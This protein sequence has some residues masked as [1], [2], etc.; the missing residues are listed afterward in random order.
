MIIAY[1]E[2]KH[3][4]EPAF[5]FF[6]SEPTPTR[7]LIFQNKMVARAEKLTKKAHKKRPLCGLLRKKKNLDDFLLK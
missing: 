2:Q 3:N 6:M 4:L 1:V 7:R 5:L